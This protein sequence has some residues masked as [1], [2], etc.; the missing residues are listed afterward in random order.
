MAR[1]WKMEGEVIFK[2]LFDNTWLL[3]FSVVTDKKRVQEGT[4]WLFDR[5]VLVLKE[6]EENI[7]PLQM[8]FSISPFWIQIHDLPLGCMTREVGYK[9]GASIG[10]VEDVRVP[11][12]GGSWS[13]GLRVRVQVDI[14]KPL[15]RG[16][17]LKLNGKQAWVAFRYEKLPHFCFHCG[18]ILHNK[19]PCSGSQGVNQEGKGTLKPW[20]VWLRVED[21]R[22]A[23]G[24]FS[25]GGWKG[26]GKA[27]VKLSQREG[28]VPGGGKVVEGRNSNCREVELPPEMQGSDRTEST[29]I[30]GSDEVNRIFRSTFTKEVGKDK[31]KEGNIQKDEGETSSDCR[32][33]QERDP[34]QLMPPLISGVASG[35]FPESVGLQ[36]D[37]NQGG[38]GEEHGMAQEERSRHD[39]SEIKFQK[40]KIQSYGAT[41]K[42]NSIGLLT[43]PPEEFNI[44]LL[45]SPLEEM[46]N[47]LESNK[48]VKVPR[49]WTRRERNESPSQH[50]IQVGKRR[51]DEVAEE[52]GVS[53][54]LH[55]E[56]GRKEAEVLA[57]DIKEVAG[58]QPHQSQ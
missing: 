34:M 45:T 29:S 9:I 40:E 2:E 27:E 14:T 16:R 11:G 48:D 41:P 7:S 5:S 13:R 50:K 4:P 42:D 37:F 15:E 26:G 36:G 8:D 47:V 19:M 25:S 21:N 22:N 3:E 51:H 39:G 20:G 23:S 55:V 17:V 1:L 30:L 49:K 24:S 6:V 53:A 46:E 12:D 18:R 58:F 44:G 54:S 52:E 31:S 28:E 35:Q 56:K 33:V 38:K 43:S 10:R 32:V 57:D